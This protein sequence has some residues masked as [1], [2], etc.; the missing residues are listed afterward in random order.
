MDFKNKSIDLY[1]L[2]MLWSDCFPRTSGTR[3]G[4]EGQ[5]ITSLTF[6]T[7]VL[8]KCSFVGDS[9]VGLTAYD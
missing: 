1:H 8:E 3:R 5:T 7:A 9:C 6:F 2:S 4:E